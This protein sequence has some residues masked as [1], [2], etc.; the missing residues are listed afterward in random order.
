[1]LESGVK[2][3]CEVMELAASKDLTKRVDG[4]LDGDL[5]KLQ[6]SVNLCLKEL[7]IALGQVAHASEQVTSAAEQ[8]SSGSEA[9]SHGASEQA[10]AIEEVSSS[11]Q[12]MLSRTQHNDASAKEAWKL[13]E[14]SQDMANRGVEAMK[15]LSAAIHEIKSSA[16][17]TAKIIKTIDEIAFQTNL[18][19]LNAAVEAARAGEAGKGFAVV[20][21]E[22]R[23]LAI[24]SADAAKNTA[25]MID[26]S[27]K[28]AEGGVAIN[29]SVLKIL[30]DINTQVVRVTSVMS[31]ITKS[32]NEQSKGL[33]QITTAVAQMNQATQ[34]VAANAEE[35]A[36]AAEELRNQSFEM[37]TMVNGFTLAASDK[38]GVD[39]N[40]RSNRAAPMPSRQQINRTGLQKT[41]NAK[42]RAM[43]P[44]EDN[45]GMED[46]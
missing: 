4:N 33:A 38:S 31:D 32:I 12:E 35:S 13:S 25:V 22:V 16:D 19:A 18:L 24:R 27:V 46:F 11:L 34:S 26:A 40:Y 1:V 6:G 43:I 15:Q 2:H 45:P 10:S 5:K 41:I 30:E 39:R 20:A 17:S 44:F 7:N 42:A 9:L 23:N 28:K 36:S 3:I 14:D 29:Q 37:E 8:I 21:E